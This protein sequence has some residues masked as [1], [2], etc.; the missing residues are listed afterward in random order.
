MKNIGVICEYNPFHNGHVKQLSY[1]RTLGGTVCLMSGNY[2][3]R[4]EPAILDKYVRAAAAVACGADLVLELSVTCALRSAEGFAA[5]GVEIL[6]K[7][8]CV[9]AL[10]FGCETGEKE[11]L[12]QTAKLLLTEQFAQKLRSEL[13]SGVSFPCARQNALEDLGGD[14]D[15]LENP[16]DILAVEYCKAILQQGSGL[17]PL[18]ILREGSYLDSLDAENPSAAS[19]RTLENWAE[20]VPAEALSLYDGAVRYS[21]QSGERAWLARLRFMEE[22]DFARLPFGSEGLW[23]K[24]MHACREQTSLEEIITE[25]KS[26]RYTRTRIM[27]MLLCA[28]LGITKELLE[29]EAPYVRVLALNEAGQKILRAAREKGSI[30]I[31]NAGET[32]PD[33]EY[34][35]LERRA[36]DLYGLFTA[37]EPPAA[38]GAEERARAVPVKTET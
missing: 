37:S 12:M 18:P 22:A 13:A 31:L 30:T 33:S 8:G 3:Q 4:G 23:R 28:Y 34:A 25:T 7:L 11:N 1:M 15:L 27:R 38:P 5:G 9:D 21:I 19:L 20:Y 14:G 24:L 29:Q 6:T 16:N 10:C 36:S 32:A 2:V 26:K 35:R 17:A